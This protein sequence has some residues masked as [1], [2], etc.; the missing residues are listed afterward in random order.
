MA[1]VHD[2]VTGLVSHCVRRSLKK[3]YCFLALYDKSGYVPKHKDRPQCEYTL[4]VCLRAKR[5]WP[6][7][8]EGKRIVLRDGEAVLYSGASTHW[9]NR[10]RRENEVDMVLFHFVDREFRGPLD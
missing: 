4:G 7:F 3:S 5:P 2:H 10:M 8:V 1:L 9:R 6:F